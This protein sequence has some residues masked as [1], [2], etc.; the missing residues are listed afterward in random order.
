MNPRK[1]TAAEQRRVD[2]LNE[3]S[4][5]LEAEGYR[6][7]DLTISLV[8]ANVV[9]LAASIPFYVILAIVYFHLHPLGDKISL[10][11]SFGKLAVF[12]PV[13]V[14]GTFALTVVHELVHGFFWG[15]FAE[16]HFHDIA[17]GIIPQYGAAYCT[18]KTPLRKDQYIVGGIMPLILV[19]LL[20]LIYGIA[21]GSLLITLVSSIM[22]LGAGGDI[23]IIQA[24][25]RFKTDAR[26]VLIYD[27][28]TEGGSI[29]FTR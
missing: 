4:G 14:I 7:T 2:R 18:C 1:L 13:F 25:L 22:T 15:L 17:F 21:A 11:L 12:L 23:L 9:I 27:H 24:L 10:S 26:E 5:R 29:V 3:V 8:R 20:P 6:R 16:H 19:G 28:P